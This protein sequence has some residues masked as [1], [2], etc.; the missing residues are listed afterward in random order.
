M[1]DLRADSIIYQSQEYLVT[2]V[3]KLI[4]SKKLGK[5]LEKEWDKA[6]QVLAYLEGWE[7]RNKLDNPADSNFI[8]EC[9]IS[10][11][12]LNQFPAP[13]NILPGTTPAIIVGGRG[14]PGIPGAKGDK[15]D[16]GL[17]KDFQVVVNATSP[18]DTF[19][20]TDAKGARWD[21]VVVESD[22]AQRVSS[23]TGH[24]LP[25]GT[26]AA[27]NDNGAPD[28]GSSTDGIEFDIQIVGVTVQLVAVVT[29]GSWTVIGTRYFIPNNGN[30]SGP[31]SNVLPNG[32]VYIGNNSNIAQARTISGAFSITNTGVATLN[33]GVI[34]DNHVSNTASIGLSK[35]AT[36]PADAIV[37]TSSL[38]VLTTLPSPSIVEL[39]Y[40]AGVSSSIQLQLTSKLTD[41]TTTIGDIIY[42]NGSNV[43]ARLPIGLAGQVLTVS[44]GVP[45]WSTPGAG[46]IQTLLNL[47]AWNMDS[48]SEVSI[49]HG[50]TRSK[51]R[52]VE[53]IIITDAD[54]AAP[55]DQSAIRPLFQHNGLGGDYRIEAT[56]IVVRRLSGGV[57]DDTNYDNPSMNRGYILITSVP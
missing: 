13:L 57:F 8:L 41:P 32:A 15:G 40:V 48:T 39:G 26:N 53:V 16:T 54:A 45:V 23:I 21:Y 1:I 31:I 25:D 2:L 35:L 38:G 24:W 44:G 37:V 34:F 33:S 10:L 6:D 12:D 28:L 11:C 29:S 5:A 17:A 47:G 19:D 3:T 22:G 43:P 46:F 30:G 27:L 14:E 20:I 42:R 49:P 55:A 9:L 7:E 18:V 4:D 50:L 56:N 36:L 52:S 51:I